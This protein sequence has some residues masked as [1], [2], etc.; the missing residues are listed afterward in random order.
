M[1]LPSSSQPTSSTG[2]DGD[3]HRS[4]ELALD[5]IHDLVANQAD[6]GAWHQNT[7]SATLRYT[8]QA[9]EA[10]ATLHLSSLGSAIENGINW[11]MNMDGS[12]NNPED[13]SDALHL[14]PSRFKTLF[15][16]GKTSDI[17]ILSEFEELN[18]YVSDEGLIQ[19]SMRNP[20]LATI[21]FTDCAC[22]LEQRLAENP[23]LAWT[24][25]NGLNCIRE[26][27]GAW[28]E[29]RNGLLSV[30]AIGDVSYA[31]D[32]LVR[33]RRIAT[34]DEIS[35]RIASEMLETIHLDQY[36]KQISSDAL[37]SII[38][39]STHFS[40]QPEVNEAIL[41]FFRNLI[42]RLSTQ[43][44]LSHEQSVS[45]PLLLRALST[46][47]GEKFGIVI[48]SVLF[49]R[50]RNSLSS[51]KQEN[52]RLLEFPFVKAIRQH[53]AV[54]DLNWKPLTGGLSKET[55]YRA[56]FN[57]RYSSPEEELSAL[58]IFAQAQSLVIKVG[59]LESLRISI[60]RYKQLSADVQ[61]YF[62]K[63]AGEP[64]LDETGANPSALLVLEDLTQ[65][66]DTMCNLFDQ[67]DQRRLSLVHEEKI[68]RIVYLVTSNLFE[69]YA[70]TRKKES[71]VT[72]SQIARLYLAKVEHHLN[73]ISRTVP[74]LKNW[75][76]GFQL[77]ERRYSSILYYISKIESHR[78]KLKI[79]CLMLIHN[80]CHSRNIMLDL[81]SERFKLIDLDRL[82]YD[83]DY[84]SDFAE[85]V[86]DVAVFRFWFDENYRNYQ[87]KEQ[88][89][90]PTNSDDPKATG[91]QVQYQPVTSH[92]V[93]IFQTALLDEI[94][95]FARSLGDKTWK[96][97]LWL[98]TA[99]HIL[100]LVD[101]H[102]NPKHSTALYVEAVQLLDELTRH[103]D[104]EIDLRPIPFTGQHFEPE[105]NGVSPF[106]LPGLEMLRVLHQKLL[107]DSPD[108]I[109]RTKAGGAIVS[110]FKKGFSEPRMIIFGDR[111]PAQIQ[112]ACDVDDLQDPFGIAQ[113][114]RQD[115]TLNT[116]I[117]VK[118]D[119]LIEN[120]LLLLDQV[121]RPS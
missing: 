74:R 42:H 53:I 96:Q 75:F 90:F 46:F 112:L 94:E 82:E 81:N 93:R 77:G 104:G 29:S 34:K 86:E 26:H 39:L 52:L 3:L 4:A 92:A 113:Q 57:L 106:S 101:K 99:V 115:H 14:N 49:E 80:D 11:L 70:T 98:A 10:L 121:L 37:Y 71:D 61:S 85:L 73:D 25:E 120:V 110:Y 117:P 87:R 19:R 95:K 12:S 59:K 7:D 17:Y 36:E 114:R 116:I 100:S 65:H 109:F 45:T 23:N 69:I 84:I 55:V 20:L 21:I 32:V 22:H 5:L 24:L 83:G 79:P 28:Y 40:D 63:H 2:S 89:L 119:T 51:Q 58:R 64:I 15:K 43:R 72:G 38:Q 78:G 48:Q 33:H 105:S 47:Y 41:A 6:D 62:A 13:D 66:Y 9:L 60:E 18:R 50:D 88:I 108:L 76:Q 56:T 91:N 44:N 30:D 111:S 102:P 8:C 35:K 16:L 27:L 118:S 68:K 67:V 103:L 54:D 107:H 1:P 97:R 31:F